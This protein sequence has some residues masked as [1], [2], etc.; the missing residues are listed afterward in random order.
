MV[1]LGKPLSTTEAN[2]LRTLCAAAPWEEPDH[3]G[4]LLA[5]WRVI[6][7]VCGAMPWRPH[8]WLAGEA[9]SGKTW[10]VDNIIKPLI[11][12]VALPVQSKTTEAGIR[13]T[14]RCN[15]LPV[16]FDEAETQ[17]EDDRKRM[18]LVLDLA[19]QASSED[20]AAIVK[21]SSAGKASMY[22]VRSCFLFSL[23]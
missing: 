15:A 9:G 11:G 19:R 23:D 14:L 7:P 21:G 6:A 4:Q 1:D 10:V 16:I 20:G 22:R 3:M 18:Q 17:N 5:G 8:L 12:Q 2:K 13:Q